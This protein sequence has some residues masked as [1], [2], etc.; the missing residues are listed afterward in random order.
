MRLKFILFFAF[1]PILCFGQSQEFPNALKKGH[2]IIKKDLRFLKLNG[3]VKKITS[4]YKGIKFFTYEF[5]KEGRLIKDIR[6]TYDRE[7]KESS[8]IKYKYLENERF[9]EAYNYDSILYAKGHNKFDENGN[10]IFA[11]F[12]NH[13]RYLNDFDEKVDFFYDD[14]CRLLKKT[15]Y[16]K[17]KDFD[18]YMLDS[19]LRY[20][21]RD[22]L[23]GHIKE[24]LGSKHIYNVFKN[25]YKDKD[26]INKKDQLVESSNWKEIYKIDQ[27][28]NVYIEVTSM[29][30]DKKKKKYSEG[31]EK[32]Y[33]YNSK[34]KL[35]KE[36]SG[37]KKYPN[38]ELIYD[39]E[40]RLIKHTIDH[41]Y[42]K[43]TNHF[44]YDK[45]DR[46]KNVKQLNSH[47]SVVMEQIIEF[48][49]KDN[50]LQ[51]NYFQNGKPT[52]QKKYHVEYY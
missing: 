42:G 52:T 30:F 15:I 10:I 3:K 17:F 26:R 33:E 43:F 21:Y 8:T 39:D 31:H 22:T 7:N 40:N 1:V 47:G 35:T 32:R 4:S 41:M 11:E 19:E 23:E 37:A 44:S 34:G 2:E 25:Y 38:F 9:Y 29:L 24:V 14:N 27:N 48:D 13:K 12:I 51:A 49:E 5:D 28:E 18:K 46:V 36:F 20:T 45:N 6:Y 16:K 50:W